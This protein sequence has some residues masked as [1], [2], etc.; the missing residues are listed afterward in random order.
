MKAKRKSIKV[1]PLED[2]NIEITSQ[3]KVLRVQ[4]PEKRRA[5][6]KVESVSELVRLLKEEARII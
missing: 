3:V 2:F 4:T 6:I 5:G 1:L